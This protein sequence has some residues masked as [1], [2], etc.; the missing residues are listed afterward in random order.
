MLERLA[1]ARKL[2]ADALRI[3][4][5]PRARVRQ[6][7]QLGGLD[8]Q[9]CL[10]PA[11]ALGPAAPQPDDGDPHRQAERHPDRAV[12]DAHLATSGRRV[13]PVRGRC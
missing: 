5:A 4:I 13:R 7:P 11:G 12:P 6:A 1:G 8:L 9:P 2:A 10:E 3:G